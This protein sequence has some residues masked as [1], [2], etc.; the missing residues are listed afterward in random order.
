M[1]IA[2][3]FPH[4]LLKHTGFRE[5]KIYIVGYDI[6][7]HQHIRGGVDAG[8][9]NVVG[10]TQ[11]VQQQEYPFSSLYTAGLSLTF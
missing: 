3:N 2:Y 5:A 4:S 6:W 1:R 10:T 7:I 8:T 11:I 9:L